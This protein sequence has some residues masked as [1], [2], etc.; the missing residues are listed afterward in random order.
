M[1]QKQD[2]WNYGQ[3]NTQN[4]QLDL[5][6]SRKAGLSSKVPNLEG[7]GTRDGAWKISGSDLLTVLEAESFVIL[8]GVGS[9]SKSSRSRCC[10]SGNRSEGSTDFQSKAGIDIFDRA[11]P[12][13]GNA[14]RVHN[15]KFV[16]LDV[17][18]GH[19]VAKPNKTQYQADPQQGFKYIA[20]A[21]KDRL[22]HSHS[23]KQQG[24]DGYQVAGSWTLSHSQF[25]SSKGAKR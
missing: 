11:E 21:K 3:A 2:S 14:E 13:L 25:T 4:I 7:Q 9:V 5:N 10:P 8:G 19:H 1:K 24:Q 12:N 18:T 23:S 20:Q 22:A 17:S 15:Q 6:V 16:V